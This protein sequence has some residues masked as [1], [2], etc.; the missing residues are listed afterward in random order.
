MDGD[1]AGLVVANRRFVKSCRC[2]RLQAIAWPIGE[3]YNPVVRV[4]FCCSPYWSG[5]IQRKSVFM[6]VT[7]F[8]VVAVYISIALSRLHRLAGLVLL[9]P[10]LAFSCF[11][12]LASFEPGPGHMSFRAAYALSLLLSGSTIIRVLFPGCCFSKH[13][14]KKSNV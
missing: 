6:G 12:F 11:G 4:S 13:S 7:V 10:I 1:V 2:F 9:I 14:D 8:L 3:T 5:V